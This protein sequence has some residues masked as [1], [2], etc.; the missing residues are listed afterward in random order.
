MF[1]DK[2]VTISHQRLKVIKYSI[3]VLFIALFA[4]YYFLQMIRGPEYFLLSEMNRLRVTKIT[5]PRGIITD[6]FGR[7][8][9]T[10]RPSYNIVLY[11]SNLSDS[12]EDI[13]KFLNLESEFIR[14][15]I[16]KYYNVP[17]S[18][19]IILKEDV[20]FEIVAKLE[21]RIINF[22][23]LSI[24]VEP[25][26][27]YPYG[28]AYVH[29]LGY[30]GEISEREI[31]SE[32]FPGVRS[33]ELIG[34]NGLERLYDTE[35]RG[36][37]GEITDVVDS[38]GHRVDTILR[39]DPIP[40]KTIKLTLDKD[41]QE[42]VIEEMGDNVGAI[43]A[44]APRTGEI[45][46]MYSSPSYDPNNLGGRFTAERWNELLGAENDPLQNRTIQNDYSPGSMF[47]IVIALAGLQ[48]GIIKDYTH[49]TCRGVQYFYRQ[50]FRCNKLSGHGRM[51][52]YDAIR[53]SCN[54]FFYNVGKELEI[55]L[56]NK[57]AK[58]FGFG[59]K[60][61]IDLPGEKPGLVPGREW[62]EKVYKEPWYPG[63]TISVSIGQGALEVTPLQQ[64]LFIASVANGGV[65]LKPFMVSQITDKHTNE[66][67]NFRMQ[68]KGSFNI[69][70]EYIDKVKRGM[71][72]VVNDYGTGWGAKMWG[73]DVAGKT[74]TAQVVKKDTIR[75]MKEVPWELRNHSWFSCFAPFDEPQI[76]LAVLVEHGGDGS[77]TAAPM[78]GRILRKYFKILKDRKK[79]N[80]TAKR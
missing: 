57:Y 19:P 24:E 39:K 65:I 43:V 2:S 42:T 71:W 64:S 22:P 56:I 26:R 32:A 11:R 78:A 1:Q 77:V 12:I 4:R 38:T 16:E 7:I 48:E 29:I 20:P 3:V 66:I 55:D 62:K 33:G 37:R 54:I 44:I 72:G 53:L 75:G 35:L 52:L 68:V 40:G 58:N 25:L 47:K 46:A 61:G 27:Y 34:K 51:G 18:E 80:E 49:Y 21:P 63:E 69:K 31:E 30:V 9:A 73:T 59:K 6:R 41:L 8:L 79:Q 76:S 5:A 70:Q 17:I 15:R 36:I 74:G 45:L 67:S 50:P 60:T 13:A 14:S 28:K 23:N 10:N